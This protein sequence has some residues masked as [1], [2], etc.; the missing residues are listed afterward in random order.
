MSEL[1]IETSE[2]ARTLLSE[3]QREHP[4]ASE[5]ET[6]RGADGTALV[7]LI[8]QQLPAILTAVAALIA[9]LKNKGVAVRVLKDGKVVP[10]EAL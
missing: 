9:A 4:D 8:I 5:L 3:F 1:V 6:I 7:T 2:Q 10:P